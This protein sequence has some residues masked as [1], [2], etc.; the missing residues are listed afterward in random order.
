MVMLLII[1]D[2]KEKGILFSQCL[3]RDRALAHLIFI[4]FLWNAHYCPYSVDEETESQGNLLVLVGHTN[5]GYQSLDSDPDL[6]HSQVHTSPI[7]PDGLS[8]VV[9]SWGLKYLNIYL[10]PSE[11]GLLSF[12]YTVSSAGLMA[13]SC[14]ERKTRA[15]WPDPTQLLL[16]ADP[17]FGFQF[18]EWESSLS[19]PNC[20]L[21]FANLIIVLINTSLLFCR[22]FL[23]VID[24][25]Q[26]QYK[27]MN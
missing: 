10:I 21:N 8:K 9:K 24:C 13:F 2:V 11:E 6:S 1:F 5:G 7:L 4:P 15:K 14:L 27:W 3:Q 25:L 18:A 26:Y 22:G 12:Q 17:R 20:E 23:Q 19:P 16:K